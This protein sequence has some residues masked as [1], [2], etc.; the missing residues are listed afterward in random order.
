MTCDND[1]GDMSDPGGPLVTTDKSPEAHGSLLTNDDGDNVT[2]GGPR[3][4]TDLVVVIAGPGMMGGRPGPA[5]GGVAAR[6]VR[7]V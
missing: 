6:V 3:V 7:G 4:T 2:P 5:T 1:D